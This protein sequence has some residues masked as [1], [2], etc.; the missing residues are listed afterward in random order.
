MEYWVFEST[1][2]F[3][4]REISSVRLHTQLPCIQSTMLHDSID[5]NQ[6]S[7]DPPIGPTAVR[8]SQWYLCSCEIFN[9]L[10]FVEEKGCMPWEVA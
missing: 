8:R 6:I 1:F 9:I 4:M 7:L 5:I 2:G 3:A 10:S